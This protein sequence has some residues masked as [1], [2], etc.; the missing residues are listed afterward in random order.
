MEKL[1]VLREA[2]W[3]ESGSANGA[4]PADPMRG[5]PVPDFDLYLF[6]MGEHRR[7]LRL[8]GAHLVEGG[9]RFA[10]WASGRPC[11]RSFCPVMLGC[12]F[13]G[14]QKPPLN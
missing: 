11:V 10:G 14:W 1:V 9:V 5:Q 2:G 4:V 8:M 3:A 6:N 13:S 7:A 12:T